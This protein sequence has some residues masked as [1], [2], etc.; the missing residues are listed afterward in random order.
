M[1]KLKLNKIYQHLK[2][3][4][5]HNY[6]IALSVFWVALFSF[7][8]KI[9]G[10]L[11]EMAIAYRFGVGPEVDAYAFIFNLVTWPVGIF[12]SI[13]TVVLI[14]LVQSIRD[15]SSTR[16]KLFRSELLGLTLL[17]GLVLML[18]SWAVIKMALAYSWVGL[19]YA[20]SEI[21]KQIALPMSLII[22]SGILVSLM[23]VWVMSNGLQINTLLDGVP[24]FVILTSLM[25]IIAPEVNILAVSTML[26]YFLNA[27]CLLIILKNRKEIERPVFTRVSKYWPI[28]WSGFG[29]LILG[30]IF[31]SLVTIIDQFYLAH[32]DEGSISTLNYANKI[33][34]LVLSMGALA[35]ARSVL[36]VFS[37]R[38]FRHNNDELISITLF[39][40][41]IFFILGL[42]GYL[43]L[44]VFSIDIVKLIFER[45]EFTS[46]N[47]REVSEIFNYFLIQTPFYFSGIVLVSLLASRKQYLIITM[48]GI[49]N[50]IIKILGNYLL[51]P[52]LGIKG[53]AIST[54]LMYV[55]SLIFLSIF[56]NKKN[57]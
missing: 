56:V 31:M 39:W 10:A 32:L 50:L 34:G 27:V 22:P 13:L 29:I 7:V 40:A 43:I 6:E 48:S 38:Q 24:A 17:F 36:P 23:S 30:Q 3:K 55:C 52:I 1:I 41:K 4:K 33:L 44:W 5:S 54:V 47:T 42:V 37:K 15:K 49:F 45:G 9:S 21:A 12:F 53:V 25:L 2:N 51:I 19:P 26:G 14:P 20:T 35:I 16:F 46:K 57:S 8:G 11:K 28:F 18:L